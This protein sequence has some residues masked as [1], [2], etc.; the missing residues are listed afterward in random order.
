MPYYYH[1]IPHS[2]WPQTTGGRCPHQYGSERECKV[3]PRTAFAAIKVDGTHSSSMRWQHFSP[4]VPPLLV[5]LLHPSHSYGFQQHKLFVAFRNPSRNTMGFR[6]GPQTDYFLPQVEFLSAFNA[7][8]HHTSSSSSIALRSLTSQPTIPFYSIEHSDSD[9]KTD[10]KTHLVQTVQRCILAYGL[11]QILVT[12]ESLAAAAA[13]AAGLDMAKSRDEIHPTAMSSGKGT[14]IK[15]TWRV[16]LVDLQNDDNPAF[17]TTDRDAV[18]LHAFHPYFYTVANL[19]PALQQR[20][21][22][23]PPPDLDFVIFLLPRQGGVLLCRRLAKGPAIG[24]GY[25]YACSPRRPRSGVLRLLAERRQKAAFIT[26]TSMEPE[27]AWAMN[28]MAGV[29]VGSKVLDP[30]VGSGSILFAASLLGAQE[31]VGTD[32]AVEL[33]GEGTG[34]AK[35]EI[36]KSFMYGMDELLPWVSLSGCVRPVPKLGQADMLAWKSYPLWFRQEYY[37]CIVT[38]PPYD[39]KAKVKGT[40]AGVAGAAGAAGAVGVG[41]PKGRETDVT[42]ERQQAAMPAIKKLIEVA[43]YGLVPGGRLVF[44]LPVWGKHDLDGREAT[45]DSVITRPSAFPP[46]PP[47]LRLVAILPQIFSPTFVRWLACVEKRALTT[48][49]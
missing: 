26:P 33:V 41:E 13:N 40:T 23:G 18:V 5:L 3:S 38:D 29:R 39:L 17:K 30:F 43:A 31:L 21:E 8:N 27:I 48:N 15:P 1:S 12:G 16:G 11:F 36:M 14:I 2:Y 34:T 46:L 44:F 19:D 45:S 24:K 20:D 22:R 4:Y 10:F 28:N 37:D 47:S 25:T 7:S 42:R 32:A 35:Y 49:Q 6:V 9:D